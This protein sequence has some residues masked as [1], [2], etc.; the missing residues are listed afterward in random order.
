MM[1][2]VIFMESGPKSLLIRVVSALSSILWLPV[3]TEQSLCVAP[4]HPL[5]R[6]PES[7]VQAASCRLHGWR[8]QR[9]GGNGWE[10]TVLENVTLGWDPCCFG[11]EK[12]YTR[13]HG[14]VWWDGVTAEPVCVRR[15]RSTSPLISTAD[16]A[17]SLTPTVL[18]RKVI[19]EHW[20]VP[21]TTT[22]YE[23]VR[24]LACAF[25]ESTRQHSLTDT[26]HLLRRW[27][28]ETNSCTTSPVVLLMD[29]GIHAFQ[30]EPWWWDGRKRQEKG[31]GPTEQILQAFAHW[32]YQQSGG[33][34]VVGPGLCLG[35]GDFPKEIMRGGIPEPGPGLGD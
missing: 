24:R 21:L 22:G 8:Q 5:L 9:T 28:V 34:L 15:F 33:T 17:M 35:W 3:P 18:G 27:V 14:A 11:A 30:G 20:G 4:F 19:T 23:M 32:S 6:A 7:W 2:G 25:N 13:H 1:G 10:R 26:L 29:N 31:A 16:D 12:S